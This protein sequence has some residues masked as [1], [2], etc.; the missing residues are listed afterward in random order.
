MNI[1]TI[2][3]WIGFVVAVLALLAVWQRGARR[4]VLYVVTLQILAGI[5]AILEGFKAP[6][7]HYALAILAWIGYMVANGMAR[8]SAGAR[9]VLLISGLSTIFVL[10]A[11]YVGM[12]AVKAGFVG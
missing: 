1:L 6:S 4:I 7:Y 2:H 8:R 12:H 5:V 10:I 9:Y 3:L 11:F